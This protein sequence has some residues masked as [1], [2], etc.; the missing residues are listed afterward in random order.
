MVDAWAAKHQNQLLIS[1][2]PY[3]PLSA[4]LDPAL[5]LPRGLFTMFLPAQLH[6]HLHL[7]EAIMIVFA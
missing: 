3:P 4:G 6:L 2:G 7:T 5:L 1:S